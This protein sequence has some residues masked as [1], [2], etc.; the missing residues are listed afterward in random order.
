[1][2][3]ERGVPKLLVTISFPAVIGLGVPTKRMTPGIE[4]L[5]EIAS[6]FRSSQRQGPAPLRGPR[7]A[8]QLY[9]VQPWPAASLDHR[10]GWPPATPHHRERSEAISQRLPRRETPRNDRVRR[11]CDLRRAALRAFRG[12]SNPRGQLAH[13]A[14]ATVVSLMLRLAAGKAGSSRAQRSDLAEIASSPRSSQ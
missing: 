3:D 1:M 8:A 6:L 5:I 10:Y 11:H 13:S 2:H 7:T 12:R 4:P 14:R 9:A